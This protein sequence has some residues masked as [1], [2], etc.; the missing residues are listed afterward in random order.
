M[1]KKNPN[2]RRKKKP[3]LNET[4]FSIVKKAT[5]DYLLIIY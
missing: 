3:D 2:K 5:R 1:A 4:A